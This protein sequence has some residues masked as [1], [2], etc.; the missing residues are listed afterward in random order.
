MGMKSRREI[1][2][3]L[4]KQVEEIE[5]DFSANTE[6]QVATNTLTLRACLNVLLDIR[7]LGIETREDQKKRWA[8]AIDYMTKTAKTLSS[9]SQIRFVM[10]EM[11]ESFKKMSEE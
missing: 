11:V 6:R 5:S 3:L 1:I 4:N 7:E 2:D 8:A 9:G 10:E